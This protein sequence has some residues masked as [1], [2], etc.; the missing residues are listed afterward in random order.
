MNRL[1]AI[2]VVGALLAGGCTMVQPIDYARTLCDTLPLEEYSACASRVLDHYREDSWVT[3]VPPGHSTSGPF[4][5]VADN[6]VYLGHYSSNPFH[7]EFRVADGGDVCRGAY[8]ALAGSRDAIFDVRCDDGRI[9]IA[10][11]VLDQRG[12]NGTGTVDFSDGTRGEIV[13]GHGAVGAI[14]ASAAL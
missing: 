5:I 3:N 7:A 12:R 4:A 6:R 13:F 1:E 2:A 10:D 11:L 9:G 14:P 8:D